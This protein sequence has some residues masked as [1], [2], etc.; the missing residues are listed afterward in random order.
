MVSK[1]GMQ[2]DKYTYEKNVHIAFLGDMSAGIEVQVS[3]TML[4]T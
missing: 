3:F 1:I 2:M 4:Y